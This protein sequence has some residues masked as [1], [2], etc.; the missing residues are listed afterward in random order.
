M[1]FSNGHA[2]KSGAPRPHSFK[3]N[4]GRL[5]TL[6]SCAGAT[7]AVTVGRRQLCPYV[8]YLFLTPLWHHVLAPPLRTMADAGP[9][10]LCSVCRA[11]GTH[12]CAGCRAVQYC[13]PACQAVSWKGGH[14]AA[15]R[16]LRATAC[17]TEFE[18]G[19]QCKARGDLVTARAHFDTAAGLGHGPSQS[20]IGQLLARE[21]NYSQ[22]KD[23][24]VDSL[25]NASPPSRDHPY[26]ALF[27]L[28]CMAARGAGMLHDPMAAVSYF[29]RAAVAPGG[30]ALAKEPMLT[31]SDLLI[32]S[33]A[34]NQRRL[35]ARYQNFQAACQRAQ[36]SGALPRAGT[37]P[38]HKS[39]HP[40]A[41][42]HLGGRG[43]SAA[44]LWHD[45]S[46]TPLDRGASTAAAGRPTEAGQPD[47]S[48]RRLSGRPRAFCS[49]EGAPLSHLRRMQ[50]RC[51]RGGCMAV[52]PLRGYVL[53]ARVPR[54]GCVPY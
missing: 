5:R 21:G 15:C 18:A 13:S 6:A 53:L 12:L 23:L 30:E 47:A 29:R 50:Y 48:P 22:A 33:G 3:V 37:C 10:P 32:G 27:T 36:V 43:G 8:R 42:G 24:L 14:K 39:L 17:Q 25:K 16:A 51:G 54:K 38:S 28:G 9:A 19:K 46:A 40:N 35:D 4:V 52:R 11:P 31:M 41:A 20:E 2:S 1:R 44:A 49:R 26:P 34:E 7:R 45:P